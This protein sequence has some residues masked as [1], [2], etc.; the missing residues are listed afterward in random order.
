MTL[1]SSVHAKDVREIWAGPIVDADIHV[2]TSMDAL[3]PYLEVQWLEFI[4]ERGFGRMGEPLGIK[5]IYPPGAK[6]TAMPGWAPKDGRQ[7]ASDLSQL[8]EHILDRLDVD[9]GIVNCY[10]AVDSIRYP[11][12]AAAV[13]AAINDWLVAEWL[14]KDD[15]LR[16]SIVVPA[17]S[18]ELAA[19]EID[20]VGDH[21]GFVQVLMPVRSDRLYGNRYWHP[22]LRA[23]ARH[24]LVFGLHFGGTPDGPPTPT[25]WPSYY[26]AEYVGEPT[27]YWAQLTSLIAEGAF[28]EVPGLRVSVLEGG[29]TWLPPVAW[30]LTKEWKGLRRDVP[31]VD[32]APSELIREHMRFSTAPVDAGSAEAL[33]AVVRWLGSDELLMFATDYPHWHDDDVAALLDATGDDGRRK[34]MAETARAWYRL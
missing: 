2:N 34:L 5:R 20:R 26:L 21:P 16:A 1:R 15:R 8:R 22:T 30:R 3:R 28:Q 13:A 29:F 12:F 31:W 9:F 23:I 7:P 18:P 6:S 27:L 24:D 10:F 14:D 25:G 4:R 33:E 19:R 11:E 17:R 32:R